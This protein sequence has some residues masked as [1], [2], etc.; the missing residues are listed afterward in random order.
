[1][2][3]FM[4]VV[5]VL[6]MSIK[7]QSE[8]QQTQGAYFM[9]HTA[10][11]LAATTLL[12]ALS[13]TSSHAAG[14]AQPAGILTVPVVGPNKVNLLAT[15][16]AQP[17]IA[18]G[19]ISAQALS[20]LTV[21]TIPTMDS[22]LPY[23]L[24]ILD[25]DYIGAIGLITAKDTDAKT[26]TVVYSFPAG[27]IAADTRYAI[28]PDWTIST[29]LGTAATSKVGSSTS[30][31]AGDILQIFN[32][33]SGKFENFWR[34]RTVSTPY[35]YTWRTQAGVDASNKRIP[36]G[37]GFII[38]RFSSTQLNLV[39]SGEL[40]Q[41]RTRKE[42]VGDGKLNV[43]ANPNPYPV[44]LS[45]SGLTPTAGSS[46]AGADKLHFINPANGRFISYF[47]NSNQGNAWYSSGGVL[48]STVTIPA[49]GAVILQR[50]AGAAN[51]TG[52]SAAK[53]N[54][55]GFAGAGGI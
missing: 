31:G 47:R 8:K 45:Q 43:I 42:I 15:P 40:R 10:I 39:L 3:I 7:L 27:S 54:P 35:V 9:N 5:H 20:V 44:K 26:V 41:A 49:G 53:L 32:P 2:E 4:G 33:A 12:A 25:G 6:L 48:S 1:L 38:K 55:L 34:A 23:V 36:L 19:K 37:E 13:L 17:A 22:S 46:F 28:R 16:F 29:L 30:Y 50:N 14:I 52:R 21:S 18:E 24:E 51:Q 11:R